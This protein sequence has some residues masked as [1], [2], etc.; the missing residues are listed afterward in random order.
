MSGK[1][2]SV[3]FTECYAGWMKFCIC[4][5][6][7]TVN[8]SAT[9]WM[10]PFKKMITWLEDIVDGGDDLNW[11]ID[12]EGSVVTIHARCLEKTLRLAI[13]QS[14]PTEMIVDLQ[15]DKRQT[16][17]VFYTAFRSFVESTS[18]KP[19]EWEYVT[20]WEKVREKLPNFTK[21]V[22]ISAL[23]D[24]QG[25]EI[26]KFIWAVDPSNI[27]DFTRTSDPGEKIVKFMKNMR[28]E[29]KE[30]PSDMISTPD[31]INIPENF[32]SWTFEGRYQWV[33]EVMEEKADN[34]W[35]G[36][37]LPD[38]RSDKIEKWLKTT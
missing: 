20:V 38:I 17:E 8:V 11:E 26:A 1:N 25:A 16:V 30:V 23:V 5:D 32:D 12:E 21:E 13:W 37:R 3:E 15:L 29:S 33:S 34:S 7:K 35:D 10:D 6:E 36:Y 22:I 14:Y 24:M 19:D 18:Y 28:T 27:I 31:Y 4:I 9:H 2:F